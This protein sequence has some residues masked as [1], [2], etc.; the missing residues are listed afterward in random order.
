[1]NDSS[2]LKSYAFGGSD[3]ETIYRGILDMT[4]EDETNV[5]LKLNKTGASIFMYGSLAFS[6]R[7]NSR[8]QRLDTK[9]NAARDYVDKI[10]GASYSNDTAH[11]PIATTPESC[12]AVSDMVNAVCDELREAVT[13]VAFGCCN[14]FILCSDAGH[15]LKAKDPDYNG[16]QYRKNL[17]AGRIFYGKNRNVLGGDNCLPNVNCD[18]N[19]ASNVNKP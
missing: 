17:E 5:V 3:Y 15:C 6:V 1:M 16:C 11:F 9:V 19:A 14:D 2:F 4:G 18:K 10:D 12:A 13:G 7:I 8:T